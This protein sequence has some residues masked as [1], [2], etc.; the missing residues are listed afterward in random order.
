MLSKLCNTSS[1]LTWCPVISATLPRRYTSFFHRLVCMISFL[2][3]FYIFFIFQ[4]L[5]F[6]F[7]FC[8]FGCFLLF[9]CAL[10]LVSV[11]RCMRTSGAHIPDDEIRQ[12]EEK[13]AESLTLAQIGMFNLL[14]NDVSKYWIFY[15]YLRTILT[16][17]F[18]LFFNL[19]NCISC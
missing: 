13:F 2:F 16:I 12:A 7:I 10:K 5:F 9:C 14:D 8:F 17:S 11:S 6:C 4:K 19:F 15:L 1:F 18:T 3:S